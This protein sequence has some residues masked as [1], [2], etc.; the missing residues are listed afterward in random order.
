MKVAIF[1]EVN[2]IILAYYFITCKVSQEKNLH[3]LNR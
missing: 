3:L 1:T 2:S